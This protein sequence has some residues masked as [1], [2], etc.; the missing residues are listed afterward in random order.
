[1][2]VRVPD[3]HQQNLHTG[4]TQFLLVERRQRVSLDLIGLGGVSLAKEQLCS[5]HAK[6]RLVSC[7]LNLE[8]VLAWSP[9]S[10]WLH[11]ATA[12]E[13]VSPLQQSITE[14]FG[15]CMAAER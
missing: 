2:C 15:F 3:R 8:H 7:G 1:M 9:R 13:K 6:V 4:G 5:S 10:L 12:K 11:F 14:M